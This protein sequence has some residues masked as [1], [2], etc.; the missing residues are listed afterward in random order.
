MQRVGK[1]VRRAGRAAGV[2]QIPPPSG[3]GSLVKPCYCHGAVIM[4]SAPSKA[5]CRVGS[6][7]LGALCAPFWG[8]LG[9]AGSLCSGMA[10]EKLRQGAACTQLGEHLGSLPHG[11]RLPCPKALPKLSAVPGCCWATSAPW[12]SVSP[13][14]LLRDAP[15]PA[16]PHWQLPLL[17]C[18][19]GCVS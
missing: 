16:L 18:V 14:H 12:G 10:G 11:Q 5:P 4:S 1:G 17:L 6:T 19:C 15:C 8:A 13:L 9:P 3:V 7:A 2:Q